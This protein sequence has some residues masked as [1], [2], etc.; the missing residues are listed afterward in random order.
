MLGMQEAN[1]DHLNV[2]VLGS[3]DTVALCVMTFVKC[4]GG[5]PHVPLV[6][7]LGAGDLGDS[8]GLVE[9][10]EMGESIICW[11]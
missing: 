1:K 6:L 11:L 10:L 3:S 9:S 4:T 5:V 2:G 7:L 8:G